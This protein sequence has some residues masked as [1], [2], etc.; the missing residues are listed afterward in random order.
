MS[1]VCVFVCNAC[2]ATKW[3]ERCI[4]K[5]EYKLITGVSLHGAEVRRGFIVVTVTCQDHGDPPLSTTTDINITIST[6]STT[7]P[8]L[9]FTQPVYDVTVM[10][11]S[12]P[13]FLIRVV[14]AADGGGAEGS[15]HYSFARSYPA[16]SIDRVTGVIRMLRTPADSAELIVTAN[17]DRYG[18]HKAS[19][20]K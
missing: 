14:A 10:T 20:M 7:T 11:S 8:P 3:Y 15:V 4:C 13:G 5:G 9:L 2:I 6:P 16:F 12:A 19:V 18:V 1:S 17:T